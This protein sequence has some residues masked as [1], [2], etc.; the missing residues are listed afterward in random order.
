MKRIFVLVFAMALMATFSM[1]EDETPLKDQKAKES[2]SLGYEF[3]ARIKRQGAEIDTETLISAIK[4]GLEGKEPALKPREMSETLREL[5]KKTMILA[6]RRSEEAAARNLEKGK[7]F[8]AQNKT[9]EG[10]MTL[11]SGLQYKVL[12]EGNGPIPKATDSVAVNYRGVLIDGTEFDNSLKRGGP[13]DIT[14]S[15]VIKGWSEALQLMK[16]GSKWQIFVPEELAYGKRQFGRIPSGSTLIFELEL[17]SIS[18]EEKTPPVKAK[19]GAAA[20]A[21]NAEKPSAK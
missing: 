3:G 16:T 18:K 4:S 5:R 14:V 1:A 17:V 21:P 13:A 20:P 19:P 15:G 6:N 10:V 11:P 12:N 2:Y 8:L 7:A 9:K